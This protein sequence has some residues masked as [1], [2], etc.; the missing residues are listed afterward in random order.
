M[1]HSKTS[2]TSTLLFYRADE[3]LSQLPRDSLSCKKNCCANASA[4]TYLLTYCEV[5]Y[6]Q[7]D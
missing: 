4:L 6:F 7:W 3:T 2:L 1:S 5:C